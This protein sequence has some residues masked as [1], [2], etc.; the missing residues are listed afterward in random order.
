MAERVGLDYD[1]S[2]FRPAATEEE[3]GFEALRC[4]SSLVLAFAYPEAWGT[5][6]RADRKLGRR[7]ARL[8]QVALHTDDGRDAIS[9][10]TQRYATVMAAMRRTAA[11]DDPDR[12][13]AF[14]ATAEGDEW[15]GSLAARVWPV[16]GQ[17]AALE[18]ASECARTRLFDSDNPQALIDLRAYAMRTA[19]V[20]ETL[21]IAAG[22]DRAQI[23]DAL[24]RWSMTLDIE[25]DAGVLS[26][27]SSAGHYW[28]NLLRPDRVS[29]GDLVESQVHNRSV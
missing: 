24:V 15:L 21:A 17:E 23:E 8:V 29:F 6:G 20:V 11:A 14:E 28:G 9:W 7:G 12:A 27:W 1:M 25:F 18:F 16:R 2:G 22:R 4:G 10:M 13:A 5:G 26:D 3:I 19:A